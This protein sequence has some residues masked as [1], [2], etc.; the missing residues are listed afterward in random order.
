MASRGMKKKG[1]NGWKYH[2]R[3]RRTKLPICLGRSFLFSDS[4]PPDVSLPPSFF[5]FRHSPPPSNPT[6]SPASHP[7]NGS[8]GIANNFHNSRLESFPSRGRGRVIRRF[9]Q[10]LAVPSPRPFLF[11]PAGTD[12][13]AEPTPEQHRDENQ[14]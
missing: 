7:S 3:T 13:L 10:P 8:P 2:S 9:G 12:P 5:F 6:P 4:V 11:F 14:N 1:P